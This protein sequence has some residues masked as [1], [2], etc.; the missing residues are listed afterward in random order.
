MSVARLATYLAMDR[1][2]ALLENAEMPDR[3]SGSALLAD[4]SGFTPLTE[5]LVEHLGPRR[6]AEELTILLNRV[7]TDLVARVHHFR[8]SVACFIGDALIACFPDDDGL[9]AVA[10]GLQMQRVMKQ[11]QAMPAPHGGRINLAMKAAVTAGS[12][13]RLLAGNPAIRLVDVL[14]GSP[15]DRLSDVEH[16]AYP[17]EV[18]ASARVVRRLGSQLVVDEWRGRTGVIAGLRANAI[19]DDWPV[20]DVDVVLDPELLRPYLLEPVF[21]RVAAGQGD[22]LAE[23]RPVAALFLKFSGIDYDTDDA[24]AAKLS[25]YTSWVQ[26]AVHRYGGHV[27]LITTAD[28]GSHLYAVFGALEAHEDDSQRAVAAAKALVDIPPELA[29][30]VD[31]QIGVS[32][33]RARVGAYGG[34]TRR[35]YGALGDVVNLA[36]RLMGIAPAGEIRCSEAIAERSS[37]TWEFETLGEVQLKGMSRPQ[38]VFRPLERA[39]TSGGSARSLIGRDHELAELVASLDQTKRGSRRIHLIA[40]EA[41]IGKSRLVDEL[42]AEA[43]DAGFAC[44]IGAGDSI[45]QHTPYRAWREILSDA[46]DLQPDSRTLEERRDCAVA[47]LRA[48]NVQ[49]RAPLLNDILDLDLPSTR[50]T[51]TLSSEV[52]QESLAALVGEILASLASTKPL[53]LVVDDVHWLDSLSWDLAVSVTRA[54]AQSPATIICTHRLYGDMEP[55]ALTLLA[56]LTGASRMRLGPLPPDATLALAATQLGLAVGALPDAV[57]E[58]LKQRSEGNPFYARELINA[59]L[60][61][62]Q[63]IASNGTCTI[64]GDEAALLESVPS[65]LEGVVLSRLDRLP[66]EEQLT[67]KVASVIGRSFLVLAVERAYPSSIERAELIRHLADTTQRRLTL[68]EFEDLQSGYAFQHVVTQQVT[69]E[70]LLFEQRRSLHRNVAEWIEE[71]ESD[72]LSAQYPLLVFHWNRAGRADRELE[73]CRLAGEQAATKCANT[74][75]A[76]YFSR[77]VELITQSDQPHATE[78]L[79]DILSRRVRVLA[80]LGRVEEERSDLDRLLA[81]AE[82]GKDEQRRGDVLVE[83]ADHHNRRGQFEQALDSGTRAL[84]SMRKAGCTTGEAQALTRLGKT[85]EE[86]G[87]YSQ[88]RERVEQALRIFEEVGDIGGQA[89]AVKS[90]GVIHARLGELSQ[91]MEQ[92][93]AAHDLYRAIGDR[94]GEADIL[95]NLGALSYYLGDYESTIAHTQQ[96]QPMFEEMGNRSGSARCLS[97]LGNSYSAL[98]AFDEALRAHEQSLVIYQQLE[99]VNSCADCYT[100]LGIAHHALGVGGYP[101]LLANPQDENEH[102]QRAVAHHQEAIAIRER[103]ANRAG[104]VV[105]HLNLGSVFLCIGKLDAAT[106]ALHQA[107]ELIHELGLDLYEPRAL[108]ALARGSLQ[109][110]NTQ[111]AIEYSE[112]AIEKLEGQDQLLFDEVQFTQYLVLEAAG[113]Q[114]D[115]DPFLIRAHTSVLARAE[116]LSDPAFRESFLAMY[117]AVLSAWMNRQAAP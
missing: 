63:L 22:Y 75:A 53:L 54:L 95:G 12:M 71:T 97:N 21:D 9:K 88:A 82:E 15:I 66:D 93:D 73:Y 78:A 102:L 72:D 32:Y 19:T 108:A 65:T 59:L 11:F 26:S 16:V 112:R 14:A 55:S 109:A 67:M 89:A 49:D 36:A 40:G 116:N 110:G 86:Q 47:T 56:N 68:V 106:S 79:F 52:R 91:A 62:G 44:L 87:E 35:T 77:A 10:C 92:F 103:I 58:L 29:F 45:E 74:E 20:L 23:L 90:L 104:M 1:R 57:A 64:V 96:A 100:N 80:I 7:Y 111:S 31:T 42:V 99:D 24:A 28:K 48:L 98:G 60:D 37:E 8:G 5:A 85:F 101:E 3:F 41:G 33:G 94:K 18:V 83:W 50:W 4:I 13:R 17:G 25:S 107:L 6:G 84:S 51:R 30:I 117:H 70:T 34:E 27:L 43:V 2:H 81:I 76:L 114:S 115:A 113:R 38:R 39:R 61:T 46:L 69:Y 105:S